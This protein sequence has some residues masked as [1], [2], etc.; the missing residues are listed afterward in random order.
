MKYYFNP[1]SSCEV[2]QPGHLGCD[3]QRHKPSKWIKHWLYA[4]PFGN[5]TIK[6]QAKELAITCRR[7]PTY[8]K[9]YYTR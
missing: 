1:I 8:K 5:I 9:L 3:W 6:I 2:K 4:P 7:S